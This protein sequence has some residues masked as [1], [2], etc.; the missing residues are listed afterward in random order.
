MSDCPTLV[1]NGMVQALNG[2]P[3][4][5]I[6]E[7]ATPSR[8]LTIIFNLF[9]FFQ[10]FN[11]LGARKIN[12]ELNIFEGVFTNPMFVIVWLIIVGGQIAMVV[13]GG[14]VM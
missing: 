7:T 2:E 11:M 8:H 9:V 13:A 14:R 1:L 3:L 5:K 12:D 6:F 10:I 4:Y